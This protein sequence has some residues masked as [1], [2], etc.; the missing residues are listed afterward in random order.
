[1]FNP[2]KIR[3]IAIIAHIDHGKTTLLDELLKQSNVFRENQVIPERVMDSYDQE[4]ER[5][6]TIFAKHTSIYYQDHK[7][8]IIDTPGHADFSGEVERVLGMVNSVL[9]IVD[10]REGPMPQTRFVLS[11]CLKA[12]LCPIVV[13][14]KIDRPHADP[15]RVLNE[16]FDLFVELGATDEQLDFKHCYTSAL[17]GYAQMDLENPQTDLCALLDLVVSETPY[18]KGNPSAPF[19]IQASTIAYDDYLGR[20]AC[21]RILEGKI[22]KGQQ[23]IH[24][25]KDNQ[26]V[27]CSISR[28]HGYLGL[29]KVEMER[30][31]VGDI[32]C[33]AGISEVMIGDTLCS[34]DKIVH[35]P[36]I[37]IEEPT[38]SIEILINNGP[39]VGKSGV[40][41]TMNKIRDRLYREQRSNISYHISDSDTDQNKIMVAGRG[42]LHL[43]VI[44]EAMRREGYE[45]CVSKPQ[46][47]VKTIDGVKCE[48]YSKTHVEV[49][50][51]H[52]GTVIEQLSIKRGE[53]QT[54]HTD[55][56]GITHMEFLIPTRGIMGYRN[57]FLST[58]RGLGI[59]T[60]TFETYGPWKGEILGRTRGVLIA[61]CAGRANAYASFN[62]ENRGKLFT[63]PGEEVYEGMIVGE[64]S[65]DNDL[66]VNI[67]KGRQLTNV[68]ASGT[69][70]SIILTP[71]EIFTLERAI[72][73]IRDDELIEVTPDSI[74]LRKMYLT[75]NER[76]R[77]S[78]KKVNV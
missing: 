3:N 58:T 52:S 33:L 51:E 11:K 20:Q 50:E 1:M 8:N 32:V 74:R 68:R 54:L 76:N 41:V 78:R 45:F 26:E 57:H 28:I 64:H 72:G 47:I 27:R 69:E 18:P 25:N 16:T 65:R 63:K 24:I 15:D 61:M 46:V 9:L 4:Q 66:L 56:H 53:M 38:V 35:L 70:D 21:G 75:E 55:E 43:A 5:G 59:L 40:H 36:P 6:I 44:L 2:E 77:K 62:L 30:A 60:S 19:L 12:G 42:E 71:P 22:E 73:Y 14:N 7:I 67:T 17:H 34:P 23:V 49:P 10:A 37:N 39:F 48:P 13:L 29:E 31:G